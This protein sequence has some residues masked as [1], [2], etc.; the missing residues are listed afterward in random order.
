MKKLNCPLLLSVALG[1]L[2]I[3]ACNRA[4]DADDARRWLKE[5]KSTVE[6][7]ERRIIAAVEEHLYVGPELSCD[8]LIAADPHHGAP[9]GVDPERID[10]SIRCGNAW[11]YWVK[12]DQERLNAFRASVTSILDDGGI[13]GVSVSFDRTEP[14]RPGDTSHYNG[15]AGCGDTDS[16][17]KALTFPENG[18]RV[19]DY[20]LGWGLVNLSSRGGSDDKNNYEDDNDYPTLLVMRTL[21]MPRMVVEY[22]LQLQTSKQIPSKYFELN[23]RRCMAN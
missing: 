18:I 23:K 12:R 8:Q 5:H 16:P 17:G 13:L 9:R 15:R 20:M 4:P 2:T 7:A 10:P 14:L 6:V 3:A 22:R 11:W 1:W 21:R 19:G